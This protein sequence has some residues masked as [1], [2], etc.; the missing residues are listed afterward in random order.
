VLVFHTPPVVGQVHIN[1][2]RVELKDRI[3]WDD[4]VGTEVRDVAPGA[5]QTRS[6][7]DVDLGHRRGSRRNAS[8]VK[9][10]VPG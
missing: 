9:A 10:Q 2:H 4:T 7:G 3:D 1:D 8:T 5:E 6:A